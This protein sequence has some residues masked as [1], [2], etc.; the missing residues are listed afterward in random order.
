[1]FN[2]STAGDTFHAFS[3]FTLSRANIFLCALKR[4]DEIEERMAA[5]MRHHD[6]YLKE[7]WDAMDSSTSAFTWSHDFDV[8]Y[9]CSHHHNSSWTEEEDNVLRNAMQIVRLPPL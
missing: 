8:S 5:N 9:S 4:F 7:D 1:M 2:E 6:R 3:L